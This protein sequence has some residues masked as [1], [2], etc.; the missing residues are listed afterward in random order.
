M[1]IKLETG[2]GRYKRLQGKYINNRITPEEA[3]EL[4]KLTLIEHN[5]IGLRDF[6]SNW[7]NAKVHEQEQMNKV[8]GEVL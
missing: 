5:N 1:S 2:Q 4:A 6:N 7:R 3:I 8:K